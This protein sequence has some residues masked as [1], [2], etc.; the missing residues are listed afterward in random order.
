M[1]APDQVLLADGTQV[2]LTMGQTFVQ[3][4]PLGTKITIVNGKVPQPAASPDASPSPSPS[5]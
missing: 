5:P 1:T 4:V 3:V 2:T